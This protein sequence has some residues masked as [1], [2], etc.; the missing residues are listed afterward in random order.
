[1]MKALTS[2][3]PQAIIING[4]FEQ[5]R[6][7]SSSAVSPSAC[8]QPTWMI[9]P[10][11]SHTTWQRLKDQFISSMTVDVEERRYAAECIPIPFF[12]PRRRTRAPSHP[13]R[14]PHRPPAAPA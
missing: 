2:A 12:P 13:G 1:M 6:H 8:S 3:S 7:A 11:R 9:P 10:R 5:A 14:P 4:R